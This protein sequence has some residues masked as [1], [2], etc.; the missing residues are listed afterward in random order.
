ID[1]V[2]DPG[3]EV[4]DV[5]IPSPVESGSEDH[6]RVVVEDH[7]SQI[8]H[9]ADPVSKLS[10]LFVEPLAEQLAHAL[11]PARLE[12]ADDRELL[13]LTESEARPGL[14]V[15]HG[16]FRRYSCHDVSPSG[17]A[18]PLSSRRDFRATAVA[19]KLS[20]PNPGKRNGALALL[21]AG[22]RC[23]KWLPSHRFAVLCQSSFT[24]SARSA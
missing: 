13:G 4:V 6:A 16:N 7:E 24:P 3:S 23:C 10:A 21:S 8:V 22:G 15:G 18:R 19:C 5:G 20:N 1:L 9:G 2:G 11:R 14:R 12:R 17:R